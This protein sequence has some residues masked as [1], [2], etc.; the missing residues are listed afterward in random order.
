MS[1][2]Q[3]AME[4][5]KRRKQWMLPRCAIK[6]GRIACGVCG[7]TRDLY[8]AFSPSH[9]VTWLRHCNVIQLVYEGLVPGEDDGTER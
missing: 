3:K 5:D 8:I 7:E 2:R 4:I 9:N 1:L 6:E